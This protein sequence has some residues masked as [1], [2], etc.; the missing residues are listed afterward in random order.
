MD[1]LSAMEAQEVPADVIDE[2]KHTEI[3]RKSVNMVK[4]NAKKMERIR[5]SPNR[6]LKVHS[7]VKTQ[8]DTS[9]ARRDIR[10][11]TSVRD[12]VSA[13]SRREIN[14]SPGQPVEL[15][16]SQREKIARRDQ[17]I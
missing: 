12:S 9:S 16:N 4:S 2:Y 13:S 8:R 7:K 14:L 10:K 6:Y 1:T 3:L 15:L 17:E 11:T 5:A